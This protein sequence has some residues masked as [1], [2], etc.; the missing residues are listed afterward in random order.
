MIV[1]WQ[2]LAPETLENLLQ[3]FV[4]RDGTDYGEQEYSLD[5]KVQQVRR[6]LERGDAV[7]VFS[8]RSEQCNIVP[9]DQVRD[10]D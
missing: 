1:P 9:A 7:I 3:A 5:E 4:T 2:A 6:A 8:E 10:W